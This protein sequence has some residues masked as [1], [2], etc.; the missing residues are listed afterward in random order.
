M[1]WLQRITDFPGDF[2]G[3]QEP[4]GKLTFAMGAP[5]D[6]AL[7]SRTSDDMKHEIFLLS[8]AATHLAD[9]LG[10]VWTETDPFEHGWALLAGHA[11]IHDRLGLRFPSL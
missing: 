2:A 1:A 8:P 4:F 6:M 9:A 3:I 5:A 10:G 11:D 7:F